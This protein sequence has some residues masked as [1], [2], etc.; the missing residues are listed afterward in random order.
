MSRC[1]GSKADT[2]RALILDAAA[3]LF[4]KFGVNEVSIAKIMA[5]I[6]M[7]NGGFY[8]YFSS[9]EM[10]AAEVCSLSFRKT[11]RI[12]EAQATRAGL[13]AE[14]PYRYLITQYLASAEEGRCA[15]VAFSHDAVGASPEQLLSQ[16][17]R[18]GTR[19]LF[20]TLLSVAQASDPGRTREQGLVH[21]SAMLGTALLRRTFGAEPWVQEVESAL[22]DQLD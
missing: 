20:D 9:K 2:T 4:L 10:L 7:T 12:W 18:E 14:N 22:L 19:F 21:F 15:I 8:K 3:R 1:K 6:G 13:T 16:S 17:Y 11:Q 5:E